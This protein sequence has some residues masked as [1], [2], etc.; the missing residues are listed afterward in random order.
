L[1]KIFLLIGVKKEPG[2]TLSLCRS[3]LENHTKPDQAT[4]VNCAVF[5][6][7]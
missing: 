4:F 7:R 5:V 1:T 2:S 3:M 6:V